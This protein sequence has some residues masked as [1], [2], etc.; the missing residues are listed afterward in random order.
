MLFIYGLRCRPLDRLDALPPL[1]HTHT[2]F[3]FKLTNDWK[4]NIWQKSA[5]FYLLEKDFVDMYHG[6]LPELGFLIIQCDALY[7]A[8]K[9]GTEAGVKE[10]SK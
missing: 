10:K 6:G 5:L 8:T 1:Q 9:Q 7:S 4:C 3:L 2:H